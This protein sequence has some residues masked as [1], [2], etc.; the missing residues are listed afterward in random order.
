M[1]FCL[2][3][4]CTHL[5]PAW[6]LWISLVRNILLGSRLL[7]D[8]QSKNWLAFACAWCSLCCQCLASYSCIFCVVNLA[9]SI[10][11][12]CF[13]GWICMLLPKRLLDSL[14]VH[15]CV[16]L[17]SSLLTSWSSHTKL[18]LHVLASRKSI[19]TTNIL[20]LAYCCCHCCYYYQYS[21]PEAGNEEWSLIDE[22][23]LWRTN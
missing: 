12:L 6:H 9:C 2:N 8:C 4:C 13:G 15:I 22:G 11:A 5:C 20:I 19:I 23:L 21:P 17:S 18:G 3:L 7:H 14:I 16:G 10:V 1:H